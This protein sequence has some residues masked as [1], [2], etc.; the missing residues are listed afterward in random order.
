MDQFLNEQQDPTLVE[1]WSPIL[2]HASMPKIEDA[3]RKQVTAALLENQAAENKRQALQE[4]T[5]TNVTAGAAKYDPVLMSM[6][7]RTAP[8]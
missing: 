1:K 7:R 3:Y 2:E 6:V 8:A 5:P 4:S